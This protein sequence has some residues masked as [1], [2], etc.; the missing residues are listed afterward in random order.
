MTVRKNDIDKR[1][2]SVT[3]LF[4]DKSKTFYLA[5]CYFRKI[6]HNVIQSQNVAIQGA[7]YFVKQSKISV[8]IYIF[9]KLIVDFKNSEYLECP[10]S[11]PPTSATSTMA[12]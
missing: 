7:I 2:S 10:T 8:E 6:K 5:F 1:V 12:L 3:L 4:I 11:N 9:S